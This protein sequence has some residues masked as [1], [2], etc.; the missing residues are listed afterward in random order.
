M[1][2]WPVDAEEQCFTEFLINVLVKHPVDDC[3]FHQQRLIHRND[4]LLGL[5]VIHLGPLEQFL[6]IHG[7][8]PLIS[9]LIFSIAR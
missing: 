7:S 3:L 8:S 4:L 5:L 1:G 2:K 9:F 6:K